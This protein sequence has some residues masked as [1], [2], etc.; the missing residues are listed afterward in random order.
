MVSGLGDPNFVLNDPPKAPCGVEDQGLGEVDF[1]LFLRGDLD[2]A[3]RDEF[4]TPAC[5]V[6]GLSFVQYA[7]FG[8][9][10]FCSSFVQ[11]FVN[12]DSAA[13]APNTKLGVDDDFAS[14]SDDES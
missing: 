13:V 3:L 6:E 11:F 7:G 8:S 4:F 12:D 5:K 2:A 14:L 9:C 1:P 10:H